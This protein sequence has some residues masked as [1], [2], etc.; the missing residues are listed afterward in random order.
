MIYIPP[1]HTHTHT[2]NQFGK[3]ALY[4]AVANAHEDVIELLLKANADP[5]VPNKVTSHTVVM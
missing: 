5:D 3:T 4:Y 2:H 1:L